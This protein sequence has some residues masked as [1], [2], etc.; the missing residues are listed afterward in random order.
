[1]K[2]ELIALFEYW[3]KERGIEKSYLV[4][5]LEKGLL[6]VYRKKAGLPKNIKIKIIPESGDIKFI[7]EKGEE[8]PPPTF[9]WER[10]AAQTAKQVIIQK[11]REAEK[12]TVYQEFKDLEGEVVSGRVERFENE[13]VVINVGKAEALLPHHHKLP[14]DRF[15]VGDPVK[16]YLLE[17]RKPNRGN[18]QLILSRTHPNF[19]RKLLENEVPEIGEGIIEIKALAR[20]P[21]DLTKIGVYSKNEKVDPVGTCIGDKASRI[22]SITKE[23]R[24]EKIEIIPWS[25]DISE[26]IKNSLSPAKCEKVILN[27]EKKEAIAIVSDDQLFLAIGK[28]GQNVRLASKL[29][30]WNIRVYRES[31]YTGEEKPAVSVIEG[32]DE[33]LAK[34]LAEF[35][36]SSIKSLAEAKVEEL[37]KI[38][39][40]EEKKAHELIEKAKNYLKR[41]SEKK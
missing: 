16:V 17:V 1:M 26:F 14:S 36:Y 9:P 30:G 41:E 12:N 24:G 2:R 19:V 32:I 38:P 13:N 35:G 23:L 11:I 25:P 10:I 27:E 31:E 37:V 40:I 21:G 4:E 7:N 15:K 3:E 20:F 5:S 6:S 34:K 33:K 29:T 22:K 8:V 28:R 18:Y 39:E